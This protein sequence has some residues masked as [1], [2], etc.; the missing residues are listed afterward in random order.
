ML[1]LFDLINHDVS[2]DENSAF[3]ISPV[4]GENGRYLAFRKTRS[5]RVIMAGEEFSYKFSQSLSP[6]QLLI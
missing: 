4:T 5:K 6:L 2:S 1:P 3:L